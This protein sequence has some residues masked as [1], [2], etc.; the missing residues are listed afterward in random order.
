MAS[1]CATGAAPYTPISGTCSYCVKSG[2]LPYSDDFL[3]AIAI[4][5]EV[6]DMVMDSDLSEPT[7][8]FFCRFF[9][10]STTIKTSTA[11]AVITNAATAPPTATAGN[12]S[13]S[14]ST[15]ELVPAT[16]LV[17]DC[18]SRT[19]LLLRMAC[20]VVKSPDD[21][22]GRSSVGIPVDTV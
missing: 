19:P 16:A 6:L 20:V 13:N 11:I 15:G 5:L 2:A 9:F 21:G 18:R 3:V 17:P 22:N 14:A 8:A 1:Y 12:E 10:L 4:S 7:A